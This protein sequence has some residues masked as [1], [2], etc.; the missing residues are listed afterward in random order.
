MIVGLSSLHV[1]RTRSRWLWRIR[2][3]GDF[4]ALM[5]RGSGR[6]FFLRSNTGV[7]CVLFLV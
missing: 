1:S 3:A 4:V 2:R 5:D 6:V 7:D